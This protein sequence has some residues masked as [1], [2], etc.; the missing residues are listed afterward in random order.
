VEGLICAIACDAARGEVI[1]LGNP[2]EHEVIEFARR[3]LTLTGSRS[4][5]V[6]R[7]PAVGDD[8]QRRR[9][10]IAKAMRL[11]EWSP[12]VG[13]DAG[14]SRT[15]DYFRLRLDVSEPVAV[16]GEDSRSTHPRR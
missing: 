8:P 16:A 2:E 11:L 15:I 10:D 9:P 5:L 3:I 6:F 13:L 4:E 7:P 1:N 14:L 12:E